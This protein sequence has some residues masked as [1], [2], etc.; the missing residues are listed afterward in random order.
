MDMDFENSPSPIDNG[1]EG[2][3]F[4][5]DQEDDGFDGN[6]NMP[7]TDD[8]NPYDTNFDAG[9]D[10]DEEEDPRT[11]I[12]QL[13]GKLSQS[14]RAY[15]EDRPQPDADLCKY[16]AGM[17]NKQASAGLSEKDVKEILDKIEAGED[18]KEPDGDI[19]NGDEDDN[20]DNEIKDPETKNSH[21]GD[22]NSDTIPTESINRKELLDEIFND[23]L[24][25]NK[26]EELLNKPIK[27]ISF[28]KKPF[29][30]P[31]FK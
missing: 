9:V 10:A 3:G 21:E 1:L 17:I 28:K 15:N 26:K 5:I 13:T 31:N 25:N 6:D 22:G 12:Q 30:S 20:V 27:N 11:Y 7:M 29:T 16:V 14:L 23:I 2:G 8:E 19:S 4:P 18:F 24:N